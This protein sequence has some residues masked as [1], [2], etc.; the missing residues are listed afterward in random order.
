MRKTKK[1][2][3]IFK[4]SGSYIMYIYS[5]LYIQLTETKEADKF[6]TLPTCFRIIYDFDILFNFAKRTSLFSILCNSIYFYG[7]IVGN[8]SI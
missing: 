2:T 4:K 8:S 5:Y 1:K 7:N 6:S 3:E